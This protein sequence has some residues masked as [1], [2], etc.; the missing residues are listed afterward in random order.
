MKLVQKIIIRK[1]KNT[2]KDNYKDSYVEW[3]KELD[4]YNVSHVFIDNRN[5]Y[6]VLDKSNFLKM[7]NEL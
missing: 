4:R 5:D 3:I 1:F 2:N 6:P 7:L